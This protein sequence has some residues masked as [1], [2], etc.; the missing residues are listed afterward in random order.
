MS[1]LLHALLA[2][3]AL[4]TSHSISNQDIAMCALAQLTRNPSSGW[5]CNGST[6]LVSPCEWP[7]VACDTNDTVLAIAAANQAVVPE[8][9]Y[10]AGFDGNSMIL[11]F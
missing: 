4:Q 2:L 6:P 11:Y 10:R 1:S 9:Q 3:V 8:G 5:S 7:N